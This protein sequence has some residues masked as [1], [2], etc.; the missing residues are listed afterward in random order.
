MTGGKN[1][2][3]HLDGSRREVNRDIS[4]RLLNLADVSMSRWPIRSDGA[5]TFRMVTGIA[6]K[7]AALA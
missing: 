3:Y 5:A 2:P 1:A 4:E 7:I 6:R